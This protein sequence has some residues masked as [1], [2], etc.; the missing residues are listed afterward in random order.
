[1]LVSS[2]KAKKES[3]KPRK[4]RLGSYAPEETIG[5]LIWDTIRTFHRTFQKLV[6]AHGINFGLW[7][8]LRALWTQDGVGIRELGERVHMAPPTTLKAVVTLEHAG[9]AYRLRDPKD[10]RK[11]LVYLTSKGRRLFSRVVPHMRYVNRMAVRGMSSLEQT[12][13]KRLV[14]HMRANMAMQ[15]RTNFAPRKKRKS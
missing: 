9:L 2:M 7:P 12:E 11:T 4:V 6:S 15:Q 5:F 14:K 10:S 3:A 13:V 8:F 1:M